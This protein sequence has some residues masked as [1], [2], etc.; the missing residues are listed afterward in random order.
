M[1]SQV[2]GASDVFRGIL[3]TFQNTF[4]LSSILDII[5]VATLFYWFYIFLR[6]TRAL[7]ILY[8]IIILAL[9]WLVSQYLELNALRT[10]LRW[11]VTSILVA[12][13]VVFQPELRSAL[14]K[15]GRSTRYMTDWKRLS[16][17]EI[18]VIVDELIK[19]VKVLSKNQ[20]GALMVFTRQSNLGEMIATG[21]RI[22]ANLNHKLIINIFTPKAPLHDGAIIISGSQII[23]ASCTLPISEEV[24]DLSLG[25]RH[26]AALSLTS[27]T[28]AVAIVVSEETGMVSVSANGRI[29]RNLNLEELRKNLIRHLTTKLP[30]K[31]SGIKK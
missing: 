4:N 29:Q 13:P 24:V 17:Y 8:G 5:I 31:S 19:A 11:L 20:I 30:L 9:L 2:M 14:E 3:N 10:I 27:L 16:R 18:D 25:T 21:E 28:D 15:L 26:K 6:Q 22:Y 23:A 12:I 7:G 1:N